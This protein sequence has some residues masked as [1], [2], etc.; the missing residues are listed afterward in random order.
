MIKAVILD[1]SG[2]V[3]D[4]WNATFAT[5]NDVLKE[6]GF[7]PVSEKEFRELYELPWI[8]FYEKQ[9]ISVNP[10]DETNNR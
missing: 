4:D 9:G 2:V 7:K 8:R 3:S 6:R 10:K 1:W 5:S